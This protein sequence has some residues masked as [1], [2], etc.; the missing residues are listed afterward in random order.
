MNPMKISKVIGI[1]MAFIEGS[2]Q[3]PCYSAQ[4]VEA[5]PA[6]KLI[7]WS[8]QNV[9]TARDK[10]ELSTCRCDLYQKM[11]DERDEC[12]AELKI[13]ERYYGDKRHR[14]NNIKMMD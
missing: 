10:I 3:G 4:N 9:L 2:H 14:T 5:L 6:D 11:E 1:I 12:R 8:Q 13:V 7:D